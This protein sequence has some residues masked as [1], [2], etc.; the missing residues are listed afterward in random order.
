M[1]VKRENK[2]ANNNYCKKQKYIKKQNDNRKRII[3]Y[4]TGVIVSGNSDIKN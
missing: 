4:R 1:I 3:I 2:K